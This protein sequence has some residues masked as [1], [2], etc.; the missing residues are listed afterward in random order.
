MAVVAAILAGC[1]GDASTIPATDST[2]T[3]LDVDRIE[4]IFAYSP[5]DLSVPTTMDLFQATKDGR[6]AAP[7]IATSDME[8]DPEWSPDGSRF[9]L[10][11]TTPNQANVAS[12]WIA[13]ADGSGLRQ[14]VVDPTPPPGMFNYQWGATWSPDGASIAFHR[15]IGNTEDGLAVINA[16]GTGLRWILQDMNVGRPSW[17]V[18]GLIAFSNGGFIWTIRPDGSG[19]TRVTTSGSDAAPRWSRDGSRLAFVQRVGNANNPA[20]D[21][22]TTHRDGSGRRTVATGGNNIDPSWSP[23]GLYILFDHPEFTPESGWICTLRKVPSTRGTVVN[24]TPDRGAGTCGGAAW[25]P[26]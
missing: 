14:L 4:I 21:I 16:D 12:I 18:N 11:R 13:N 8:H 3:D 26:F 5:G 25:R 6:L 23:D 17:S 19:L 2:P 20:F 7:V 24:L 15:S 9:T 22:V 10:T 1:G